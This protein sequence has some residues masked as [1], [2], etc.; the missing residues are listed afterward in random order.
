MLI[1]DKPFL[2][3]VLGLRHLRVDLG[4]APASRQNSLNLAHLRRGEHG[5]KVWELGRDK[6]PGIRRQ[7]CG[8]AGFLGAWAGAAA[9]RVGAAATA[10]GAARWSRTGA[11]VVRGRSSWATAAFPA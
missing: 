6:T 10:G 3:E 7:G 5:N 1:G 9:P 8:A 4:E 11:P 2:C